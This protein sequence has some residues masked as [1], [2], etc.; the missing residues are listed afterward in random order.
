MM[1]VW[2]TANDIAEILQLSYEQALNFIKY[3]GIKFTKIGRQYR[4]AESSLNAFLMKNS[5]INLDV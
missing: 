3:S 1:T 4:V 2:L 5:Y